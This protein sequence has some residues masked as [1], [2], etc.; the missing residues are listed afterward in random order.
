MYVP[1]DSIGTDRKLRPNR[2]QISRKWT[3]NDGF[4]VEMID[5]VGTER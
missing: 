4:R 5:F 1:T 3:G 2:S